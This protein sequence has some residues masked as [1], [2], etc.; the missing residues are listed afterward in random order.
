[1]FFGKLLSCVNVKRTSVSS[2]DYTV[3][4]QEYYRPLFFV[5]DTFKPRGRYL[6]VSMVAS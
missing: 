2:S 3:L 6:G 4:T 5:D 1:M